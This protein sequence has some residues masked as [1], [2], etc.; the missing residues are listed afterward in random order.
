ME[1]L[2]FVPF[3]TE[4]PAGIQRKSRSAHGASREYSESP[5]RRRAPRGNVKGEIFCIFP[6]I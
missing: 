1:E 6:M 3:G 2:K 4:R 5:V